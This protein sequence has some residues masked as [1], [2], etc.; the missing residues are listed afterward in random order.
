MTE[1]YHEFHG[2]VQPGGAF[3]QFQVRDSSSSYWP[4]SVVQYF[5]YVIPQERR[6]N[7]SKKILGDATLNNFY[8]LEQFVPLNNGTIHI[9]KVSS[10]PDLSFQ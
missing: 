1:Q 9:M 7:L 3:E 2:I 10:K 5:R 4:G 8:P 6:D